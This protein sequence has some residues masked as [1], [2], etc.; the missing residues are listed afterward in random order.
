MTRG[1]LVVVLVLCFAS[2]AAPAGAQVVPPTDASYANTRTTESLRIAVDFFDLEDV[3]LPCDVRV[4]EATPEQMIA[5]TGN[6]SAGAT[7]LGPLIGECPIWRSTIL[8]APTVDNRIDACTTDVHEFGHV[9]LGLK[10]DDDPLSIMNP[11]AELTV[12]GC[13]QRFIGRAARTWRSWH[14]GNRWAQ[15]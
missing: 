10:H 11:R 3:A 2:I 1:L 6:A 5:F 8:A 13:Y 15:R 4:Y 7:F 9:V 14:P 12:W